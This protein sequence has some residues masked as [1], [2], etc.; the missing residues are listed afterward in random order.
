MKLPEITKQVLNAPFVK[1]H[2]KDINSNS[3]WVNLKDAK[4]SKVTICI[5][6]GW[7]IKAD[8]DVHII[9]GDVNFEDNGTLGDVGNITTMPSVNVLKVK[10]IKV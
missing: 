1:V 9:V 4:N 6:T 8:K 5:T 10:R 7:L 3:S 2:W